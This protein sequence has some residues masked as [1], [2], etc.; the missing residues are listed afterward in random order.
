MATIY[1]LDD[2]FS[3][4]IDDRED[5]YT[6]LYVNPSELI[7]IDLKPFDSFFG[8]Q[9]NDEDLIFVNIYKVNENGQLVLLCLSIKDLVLT[10]EN[11]R[12]EYEVVHSVIGPRINE[13]RHHV[14]LMRLVDIAHKEAPHRAFPV[15]TNELN[16]SYTSL[17][18]HFSS[19]QF[20]QV[21]AELNARG[22]PLRLSTVLDAVAA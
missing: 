4:D 7:N 1:L 22:V 18:K 13:L 19:R 9:P 15:L 16:L 17:Y 20:N 2:S 6:Y 21:L 10:I 11:L 14:I 5:G 12:S 3:A 8:F